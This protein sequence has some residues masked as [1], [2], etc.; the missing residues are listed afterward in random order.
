MAPHPPNKMVPVP[1]RN[2]LLNFMSGGSHNA[3][4]VQRPMSV[5][6]K[7]TKPQGHGDT[8]GQIGYEA[9]IEHRKANDPEYAMKCKLRQQRRYLRQQMSNAAAYHPDR[10][11][12]GSTDDTGSYGGSSKGGGCPEAIS[13]CLPRRN[14]AIPI[15]KPGIM[16]LPTA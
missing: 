5:K 8:M 7:P 6:L 10:N 14:A 15:I 3:P 11:G 16:A 12:R 13:F 1:L 9:W 2:D 4:C